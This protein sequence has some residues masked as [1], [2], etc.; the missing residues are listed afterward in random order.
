MEPPV[1]PQEEEAARFAREI[2]DD[3]E[4][5][6]A[7]NRFEKLVV[8]AGPYFL[9]LLRQQLSPSLK[10]LVSREIVKNLGQY[11]TEDV[12]EHLPERL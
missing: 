12:R 8:V 7:E 11:E 1:D 2:A 9:G 10:A 4:K 3:L 5:A 6:R